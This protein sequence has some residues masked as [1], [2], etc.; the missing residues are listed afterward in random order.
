MLRISWLRSSTKLGRFE[1]AVLE[2]DGEREFDRGGPIGGF[3]GAGIDL[4]LC[5]VA[6]KAEAER[7]AT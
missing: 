5:Q 7:I 4:G 1:L 2:C 6:V 3:I